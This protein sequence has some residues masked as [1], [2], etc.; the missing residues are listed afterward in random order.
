LDNDGDRDIVVN[1]INAPALLYENKANELLDNHYIRIELKN[2]T[3]GN[4]RNSVGA[5]AWVFTKDG[6]MQVAEVYG[7]RGYASSSE[8]T[9]HFGLGANKKVDRIFVVWP[10]QK[11]IEQPLI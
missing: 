4:N 9:L 11:Q 8:L 1:N 7:T 3:T 10:D 2:K 6:N 5:R